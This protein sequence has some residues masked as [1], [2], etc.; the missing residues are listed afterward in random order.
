MYTNFA[1]LSIFALCY[2]L[3]AGRLEKTAITGPMI[4]LVFGFISSPL[5]F[6]WLSF[7]LD[8]GVL[9]TLADITLALV[10][11]IDAANSDKSVL[12]RHSAI[13]T[14][15]L[16]I[17]LPLTI[18]LG[19]IAG[20][21]LFESWGIWECAILATMLTATDAALG[22]GVV[23]NKAVPIRLREGLN[24]ESGLNDGI[25]VPLLLAFIVM[26]EAQGSS[27]LGTVELIVH[28]MLQEIGIGLIVGVVVTTI[29]AYMMN[30]AMQRGWMTKIWLQLPVVMVAIACFSLAQML[31]GSGYIAAFVGGLLFGS[32]A[33]EKT[34][35]LV[36]DAEG[37]AETLAMFTWIVFAATF[38]GQMTG[39]LTW[40]AF[41]YA[42]LSLTVVRILPMFLSLS[43]TGEKVESKLFL[44]WFGPRGFASIV[45]AIIVLT[46]EVEHAQEMAV[47]VMLTVILS[48]FLHGITASP[49]ANA[50]A[51]RLTSKS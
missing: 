9:R 47:V 50:L 3:V 4:F 37:L 16:L 46:S 19:V 35:S 29:A 31:H 49:F 18:F 33:K 26:A 25:C 24:V 1:I 21:F 7:D 51:K 44:A 36:M 48:A 10:L 13:P 43:G 2:S 40:N 32:L 27:E 14:R 23:T 30:F 6:G 12:K 20:V 39:L 38:I 42:I 5:M 17:G 22:K 11:F 34:H 41:I 28:H 15:M 8:R 45:F